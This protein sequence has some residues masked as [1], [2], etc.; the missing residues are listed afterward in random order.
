[1]KEVQNRCIYGSGITQTKNLWDVVSPK[2]WSYIISSILLM[3]FDNN[4]C[5]KLSKSIVEFEWQQANIATMSCF[6]C[7]QQGLQ[8]KCTCLACDYE[9][10]SSPNHWGHLAWTFCNIM[11]KLELSK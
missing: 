2:N 10:L 9:D 11:K 5:K 4:F 8:C 7:Q 3:K 1:M 6:S